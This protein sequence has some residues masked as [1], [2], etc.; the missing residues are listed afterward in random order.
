MFK[1]RHSS[2]FTRTNLRRSLG[3]FTIIEVMF[4]LT[5][6]MVIFAAAVATISRQN[7]RTAF[8]QSV[9]DVELQLQD[10]FNDVENGYY[11]SSN[12]FS[13]TASASGVTINDTASQQGT[14]EGC[15]FIGKAVQFGQNGEN[16]RLAVSTIIGKRLDGDKDVTSIQQ[17]RPT[18][19]EEEVGQKEIRQISADIEITDLRLSN[20]LNLRLSGI[21]VVS[22][23]AQQSGGALKSGIVRTYLIPLG[24]GNGVGSTDASFLSNVKNMGILGSI[25]LDQIRGASLCLEE[26]GGGRKA[27]IKIAVQSQRLAT[28]VT[29]DPTE[30][31]C[32]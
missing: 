15:I 6:S 30:G 17:A 9:R 23:F 1:G 21:G 13:C 16:D 28:N 29:I 5:I 14:N 19:L 3:G 31:I 24:L 10:V 26:V 22:G 2:G 27:E 4:F 8:V 18:L 25:S 20:F 7:N 12:N 11:P 32:S